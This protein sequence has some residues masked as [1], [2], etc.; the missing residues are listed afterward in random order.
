V[1]AAVVAAAV[2]DELIPRR[3]D[4]ETLDL[5]FL[6][7]SDHLIRVLDLVVRDE[8]EYA[9]RRCHD[10]ELDPCGG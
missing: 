3:A 7:G 2:H 1:A 5:D 6:V 8:R 10:R 9:P 4:D